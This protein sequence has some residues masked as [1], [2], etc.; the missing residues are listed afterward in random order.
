MYVHDAN[1]VT[2]F[3]VSKQDSQKMFEWLLK[4][5][6]VFVWKI[7][8]TMLHLTDTCNI[9]SVIVLLQNKIVVQF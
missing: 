1:L 9:F 8:F 7:K 3:W 2:D 4:Y 5:N 6:P